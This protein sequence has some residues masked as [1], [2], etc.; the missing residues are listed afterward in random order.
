VVKRRCPGGRP[1]SIY[2]QLLCFTSCVTL[3]VFFNL[4]V[5][6]VPSS[7]KMGCD[8]ET[9]FRVFSWKQSELKYEKSYEKVEQRYYYHN[10]CCWL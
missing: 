8:D 3:T 9:Y 10:I 1:A 7:V 5:L 6:S 2:A 4:S